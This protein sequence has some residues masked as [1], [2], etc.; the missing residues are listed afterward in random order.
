[1]NE[2]ELYDKFD[3]A[4]FYDATGRARFK[5]PVE[6]IDLAWVRIERHNGYAF[7]W[8]KDF[9][10]VVTLAK[11]I[12]HKTLPTAEYKFEYLYEVIPLRLKPNG[13]YIGVRIS[14]DCIR[15]ISMS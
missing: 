15:I 2:Q 13:T 8:W 12:F 5:P 7:E 6:L 14:A 10:G 4:A 11:L 9:L 3:R 1:M